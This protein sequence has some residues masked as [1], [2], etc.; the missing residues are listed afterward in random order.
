MTTKSETQLQD[1]KFNRLTQRQLENATSL[2]SA[3]LYMV[4][5]EFTGG[6]VL[7]TDNQGEIVETDTNVSLIERKVVT[8]L[9]STSITLAN[10]ESGTS[11]HYGTLTA[12]TITANDTSDNEINI[13]FTAGSTGISVS[14]PGTIQYIGSIPYFEANRSY[15]ISILNNTL[16]AGEVI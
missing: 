15:A 8:D 14:L 9:T 6:K 3:E 16:I 7:A 13:Y 2:S 10:A 1:L 11:Y 5:P 12:L 4:D